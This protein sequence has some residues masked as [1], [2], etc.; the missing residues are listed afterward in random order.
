[1][2]ISPLATD[3][4][5]HIGADW[6]PVRPNTDTALILGLCHTLLEE[7]LQDT[8]FL[9]RY[10]TGFDAFALYLDGTADGIPKTASWAAEICGL[11]ADDIRALARRMAASRT[12][13]SSAGH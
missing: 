9:T 7:G 13:I 5:D 3:M 4:P 10:C 1:M 11:P 2:N 8:E 12:M 6:L